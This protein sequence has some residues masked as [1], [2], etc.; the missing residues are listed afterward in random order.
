MM[1]FGV[2]GMVYIV[3]LFAC[4]GPST[5]TGT[6]PAIDHGHANLNF[7]P[8]AVGRPNHETIRVKWKNGL[9][10]DWS[11][12]NQEFTAVSDS[13]KTDSCLQLWA[14]VIPDTTLTDATICSL[15]G[16][17]S[18]GDLAFLWVEKVKSIPFFKVF[19]VQWDAFEMNCEYPVGFWDYV[20]A[21][22]AEVKEK[23]LGYL[24]G[25]NE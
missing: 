22:R 5:D 23:V 6:V 7:P 14:E 19:Q 21:H 1:K 15:D 20:Q 18:A 12:Q 9:T 2:L 10:L 4:T 24:S 17:L 16:R 25:E 11:L 3:I 13:C 8:A